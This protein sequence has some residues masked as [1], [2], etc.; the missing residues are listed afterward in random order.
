MQPDGPRRR[1][2]PGHDR[3]P[4]SLGS[5]VVEYHEA[6]ADL[7]EVV[8]VESWVL[9]VAPA[10]A[11]LA[12][13]LEAVLSSRHPRYTE[14]LV[15]EAHSYR[16]GWLTITSPRRV[17]VRLSGARPAVDAMGRHDLGHIDRLTETAGG[18]WELDGDWGW[19]QVE[20]PQIRLALDD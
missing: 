9:E 8:L 16:T 1:T 2:G 3:A 5:G 6:F 14:P 20:G 12:L 17:E 13:R 10:A 15:D 11:G 7:S 4:P 18:I 19:A